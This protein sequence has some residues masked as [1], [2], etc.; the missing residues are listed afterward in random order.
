MRNET[1][2]VEWPTLLLLAGTY[3][4]WGLATSVLWAALPPLGLLLAAVAIAQHSSLQHEALHGHPTKNATLNH[5]LV[6]PAI[7]LFYPYLRFRDTH[8]QHHYDPALTD[9]YDDP[10]SNFLDPEVWNKLTPRYQ[11]LL[12][13]NNTLAGRMLVGPAIGLVSFIRGDI[14]Q[15][16]AGNERIA[17]SWALH[18]I[19][20]ML[21]LWWILGV[22][23]MPV[24]AW[25]LSAYLGASLLK[26]RTYLEHRAHEKFRARTVV[27]EDKG[28]LAYLF[29]NNNY[30]VVHHMHPNVPWYKLPEMYAAKR[31]HYQRRND[32]YVFK[33]YSEVFSKYFLKAKDPVPHPVWPVNKSGA[34]PDDL[35]EE[36]VV[37]SVGPAAPEAAAPVADIAA[38]ATPKADA[39]EAVVLEGEVLDAVVVE[40]LE[41]AEPPA[42]GRKG[43]KSPS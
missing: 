1:V 20:V 28:P 12:R 30:H 37:V 32:G 24:W 8:L 34:E 29:L 22:G 3:V 13:F 33:S 23:S 35:P 31:E 39:P 18:G 2:E 5:L 36:T 40:A 15:I 9:P 41:E 25:V 11:A 6:F 17:L 14:A 7:G 26:I 16:K 19:G 43:R 27:I 38:E 4:A 42:K 21:A 10:E